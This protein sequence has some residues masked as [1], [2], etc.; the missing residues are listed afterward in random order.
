MP[1]SFCAF[2]LRAFLVA[3]FVGAATAPAVNAADALIGPD[4]WR[5]MTTGKTLHYYRDGELYGREYYYPDGEK[6]EFCSADGF[7]AVGRWAFKDDTYC[8]AYFGDLHCFRHLLRD[9]DIF[10]VDV[11]DAE[12]EQKVDHI[13]DGGPLPCTEGSKV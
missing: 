13:S 2:V 5:E 3:T 11:N 12:D 8:F 1:G 6:V 4:A 10:V 7:H 9:G